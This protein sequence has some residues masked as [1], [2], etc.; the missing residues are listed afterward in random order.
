MTEVGVPDGT[1]GSPVTT[2]GPEASSWRASG[3]RVPPA[4]VDVRA[5]AASSLP[6]WRAVLVGAWV[7][8]AVAVLIGLREIDS[9]VGQ[10]LVGDTTFSLT[11]LTSTGVTGAADGW[12]ALADAS[13][14]QG[15]PLLDDWVRGYAE[16][17]L[18]FIALYATVPVAL[19]AR[20]WWQRRPGRWWPAVGL[21]AMVVG[22]GAD[23]TESLLI[24]GVAEGT[25]HGG[26]LV[27]SSWAK[28]GGLAVAVLAAVVIARHDDRP[29]GEQGRTSYTADQERRPV[30]RAGRVL[31]GLYTH[32]FS[33]LVVV[34]FGVL[35]LVNGSDILDQIPDVQRQW[36]DEAPLARLLW[37]GGLDVVVCVVVIA[38]GRLRS[39][40]AVMRVLPHAAPYRRPSLLPWLVT[41]GVIAAGGAAAVALGQEW[42]DLGWRFVVALAVPVVVF[43]GSLAFRRRNREV[44]WSPYRRPLS[45]QQ[46]ATTRTVGDVLGVLVLVIPAL[47][48]VRAFSGPVALEGDG[49]ASQSG[50]LVGASWAALTPGQWHV[51]FL[52]VGLLAAVLTWPAARAVGLVLSRTLPR[53][54]LIAFTP[55][56]VLPG[57]A[58]QD[59][60]RFGGWVLLAAGIVVFVVVGLVPWHARPLPVIE[61]MLVAVTAVAVPLGATVVLL[62]GGGAP[63]LLSRRWTPGLR[64]APVMTIIVGTAL[65]VGLVGDSDDVH[66]LRTL[67]TDPAVPSRVTLPDRLTGFATSTACASRLQV[68]DTGYAVRPVFLVAAEGGGI[69]AAAW[70]ALGMDAMVDAGGGCA[71]ALMSSGASGGAVGLTV[72]GFTPEGEAYEAVKRIAGPDALSAA[73]TGL[74]VRD[75]VRSVTGI[76]FPTAGEDGW[77]DRAGL[78]ETVWE[79]EIGG[80]EAPFVH[81]DLDRVTGALV[82]NSTSVASRC[83]TLLSQVEVDDAPQALNCHTPSAPVD[84]VDLLPTLRD[85]CS[86]A[87][88]R[89]RASTVALLASR[90]PYVT[91]S[92]VLTSG[93]D[94]DGEVVSQQVVDGGYADNDGIGT[95]VDLSS[96]WLPSLRAHN[97]AVLGSTATGPLLVPV[98]VY[99]DNGAGS[100]IA[101]APGGDKNEVL[102]PLLT[103]GAATA[104]L[105][106]TDAQLHRA[107]EVFGTASVVPGCDTAPLTAAVAPQTPA[108]DLPPVEQVCDALEEWR[109]APVK[110]FYQPSRPSIAAPLGWVLSSQSLTTLECARDQ[111]VAPVL[112]PVAGACDARSVV[113]TEA[114]PT[115]AAP[116]CSAPVA[117]RETSRLNP[118]G[119]GSM[120]SAICLA[121]EARDA[122]PLTT[123]PAPSG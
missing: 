11:G 17:D 30:G 120:L 67:G 91:P 104:G 90:F 102:V 79:D 74:L 94:E 15:A 80:L 71:N 58:S 3:P 23:V 35:G 42:R 123:T 18:V 26:A 50:A 113:A 34:P 96:R 59:R 86:T 13:P 57:R 66:G 105:S 93:C 68:G 41:A 61:V 6:S 54:W 84:S 19:L 20:R 87:V 95:V 10:V 16:L 21:V 100:D 70:T 47:G 32:R 39:H 60:A 1:S 31:R 116:G 99:L 82:L 103:K 36:V 115:E 56:L 85:G 28:W 83:R 51:L 72:S 75:P 38:I 40:H 88:P 114:A 65:A 101:K 5:E 108:A 52:L 45:S 7:A 76:G 89:L 97:A 33:L 37:S 29:R 8:L 81:P 63:D 12:A 98:L 62:Q 25:D 111:Q 78:M 22:A 119:Y 14:S 121:R 73:V 107:L 77:I 9:L 4:E 43:L 27:V 44:P 112:E 2:T 110:V 53:A 48:L 69:R 64:T 55:G 46:A 118:K 92:G 106:A 109:G 117:A 122:P 49:L 24:R